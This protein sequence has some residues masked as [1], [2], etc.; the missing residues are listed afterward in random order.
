MQ[1]KNSMQ[2]RKGNV[3]EGRLSIGI[4]SNHPGLVLPPPPS[5]SIARVIENQILGLKEM[6]HRVILFAPGDCRIDCEVVPVCKTAVPVSKDHKVKTLSE[7]I[8]QKA[9]DILWEMHD[10][11]DIVNGHGLDIPGVL[12]S[13]GFLGEY[14]FPNVTTLHSCVELDNLAY[15]KKIRNKIISL[16]YNQRRACSCLDFVGNVYNG[17][18]PDDFPVNLKPDDYICFLGRMSARKQPHLAIQLAR[19][20]GIPIRLA[21]AVDPLFDAD[22]FQAI[23]KPLLKEPGVEYLG[24]LG[25]EDKI[26][27]ISRAKMNLHPTGFRDPCP[28]VPLEAGYCGTPTLA[29]AAGAL[30]ELIEDGVTGFLVEDFCEGVFAAE[31]CMELDRGRI[32]DHVRKRFN[33]QSM[34]EEYIKIYKKVLKYDNQEERTD[35]T[36]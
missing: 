1:G 24:E 29:I 32:A 13:T 11:I 10:E 14:P 20:I 28:L 5:H 31:R 18:N 3:K 30:P 15:F 12:Q 34:A 16:S 7:N 35:G 23:C 9:M 36:L 8:M 26:S 4:L 25:M 27:L 19:Q 22:Y 17:L 33:R 21:G 2:K 6:G